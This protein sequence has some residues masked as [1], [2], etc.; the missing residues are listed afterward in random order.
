MII[1]FFIPHAGCPHQ[2]VFCNQ[3][4]I[5]GQHES[6]DATRLPQKINEYLKNDSS[7]Y[8]AQI[9]FYGGSFT[10]LLLDT[11]KSFLEAVR[12]FIRS[13]QIKSIRLSTRPD[14]ISREVLDLLS[15]Y[16]VE[17]IELGAQSMNDRVLM[18]S[19]RGHTEADTVHAVTLLEE[20][21]FTVGLQLMPGLPGDSANGF[22]NTV[23]KAIALKPDFVRLYPTLVIKD[24]P[25]EELYH[26]GRYTPLSFD[27]AVSLCR[28]ALTRFEEKGIE[29]IRIGLQPTEELLKPGTIVAGPYHPSFRQHVESSIFLDKMRAVLTGKV[30]PE[31]KAVI[32]VNPTDI[33]ASIGQQRSNIGILKKEFSIR[34]IIILSDHNIPKKTLKLTE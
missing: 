27:E 9:A 11:Q 18:L 19:G 13:G 28:D 15:E 29:V 23:N 22:L 33:S 30:F 6:L 3:K 12:P 17:T 10:A 7:D 5:T 1:P 4:K 24:T 14:R 8:P 34:D 20:Y 31:H 25:L 21:S 2:C 32:V 26:T 16:H